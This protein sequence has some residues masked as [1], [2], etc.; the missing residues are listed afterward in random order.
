MLYAWGQDFPL[1]M[2]LPG[3]LADNLSS[4]YE[5]KKKRGAGNFV[6]MFDKRQKLTV[7]KLSK[8]GLVTWIMLNRR[9]LPS[10]FGFV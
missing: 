10:S 9:L 7:I 1:L 4:N 8:N 2:G 6:F 5:K 3:Y